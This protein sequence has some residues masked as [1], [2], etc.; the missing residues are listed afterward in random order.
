MST[1]APRLRDGLAVFSLDHN[2]VQIGL[3]APVILDDLTA[4]QAAYVASLERYASHLG[5]TSP[6]DSTAGA[7]LERLGALGVLA[8][9]DADALQRPPRVVTVH[10]ADALGTAIGTCLAQAGIDRVIFDDDRPVARGNA[11]HV[12][13]V[14]VAATRA[15]DAARVVN[16][17]TAGGA[18][19]A[20][21]AASDVEV[22]VAFGVPPVTL[23]HDLMARDQP[24]LP[25]VTDELG[26]TVGPLVIPGQTACLT[27]IGIERTDRDPAWPYV[28]L[29]CNGERAPRASA[30]IRAI[31]TGLAV[32]AVLGYL[33]G[34]SASHSRWRIEERVSTGTG[35]ELGIRIAKDRTFVHPGC[36]CHDP[37]V[38]GDDLKNLQA[39]LF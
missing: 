33:D 27:C 2:R 35:P 3:A 24:H 10:G 15:Q 22:I 17:T 18:I 20:R 30:A 11:Q 9:A 37:L 32:D 16:D 26:I 6:R 1:P 12:R 21:H 36:G 31:A 25:V 29:Q 13:N 7:L 19:S 8:E 28:A 14:S 4:S 5:A 34:S 23:T 39:I 38:V